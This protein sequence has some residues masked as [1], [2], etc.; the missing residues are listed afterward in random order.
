MPDFSPIALFVYN[1]PLHTLQTLEALAQNQGAAESHLVIFSDGVKDE[2]DEQAVQAIREVR[3]IIRQ[4]KWCGSVEIVERADNWGLAR[5][6]IDGVTQLVQR[7]GRIIVLEDDMVSA[8]GFLTYMNEA[9]DLYAEEPRVGCIHAW[10]YDMDTSDTSNTT[11]FLPGADCWGWATWKRGWDCFVED[12]I[13]LKQELQAK[14]AI[15]VFNRRGTYNYMK[16]LEDQIRGNNHSWAVRWHASLVVHD[17]LCLHPTIPLI[18]NIGT[19]GS[20]T[21]FKKPM[22]LHQ[23]KAPYLSISKIPLEE[24][25]W[26]YTQM[27]KINAKEKYRK[28]LHKV[29]QIAGIKF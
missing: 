3:A 16:M 25:M 7:F 12:G 22:S 21:H 1:R 18:E 24:A 28:Y 15:D 19:D 14:N 20:G 10:T 6:I 8:P 26:F 17:K 29:L 11:F 27:K 23:K 9:L 2:S 4:R 13:R 5:N